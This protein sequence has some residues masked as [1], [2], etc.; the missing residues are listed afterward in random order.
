MHEIVPKRG[1]KLLPWWGV[2][3]GLIASLGKECADTAGTQE[4]ARPDSLLWASE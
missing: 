3:L 4:S 2:L 1:G